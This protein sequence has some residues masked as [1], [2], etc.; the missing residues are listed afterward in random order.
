MTPRE[1]DALSPDEYRV[2]VA[3]QN[4]ETREANRAASRARRKR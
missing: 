3:Y 4:R 1:V 2:L